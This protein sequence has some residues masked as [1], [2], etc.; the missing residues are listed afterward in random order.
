[1][2]A[3]P[4]LIAAACIAL[5][6]LAGCDSYSLLDSFTIAEP[7]AAEP[8]PEPTTP[9]ELTLNI[10]SSNPLQPGDS[11]QLYPAGGTVPYTWELSGLPEGFYPDT[12][13]DNITGTITDNKYTAGHSIGKITVRLRDIAGKTQEKVITVIPPTPVLSAIAPLGSK[14]LKFYWTFPNNDLIDNFQIWRSSGG[15]TFTKIAEPLKNER[16]F[17]NTG[18]TTGTMYTYYIIAIKG[19][20]ESPESDHNY[21]TSE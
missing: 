8:E 10:E 13:T 7:P 3:R 6:L 9:V 20:Y 19:T 16:Y 17:E 4:S 14:V 11:I 18:L 15:S 2:R 5:V 1:M 21:Y 12:Y